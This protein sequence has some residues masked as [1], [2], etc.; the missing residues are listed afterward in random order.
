MLP[1]TILNANLLFFFGKDAFKFAFCLLLKT[2]P[3]CV[4]FLQSGNT[5]F[6]PPKNSI[7]T[8]LL[9]TLNPAQREAVEN[10]ETAS[11]IIA[12]AG[13]GKTRVLTSR[14]AY[15]LQKGVAPQS[16]LALTFTNKAAREMR[17]R[18]ALVAG[19]EAGRVVMG[20][21]HSIFLRIL[22]AEADKIGFD[23]NFTIYDTSD[24]VSLIKN[25]IKEMNLAD[26]VY[27]PKSVYAR[28]SNLKNELVTPMK[29]MEDAVSMSDDRKRQQPMFAE[30]YKRYAERCKANSAMDFD[31]ML[32]YMNLLL[33]TRADVLEKYQQQFR[34]ILVDEYQDTNYAQYRIVK[35]LGKAHG[36][37]CVVGD[38]SQSIYSFRGARIENIQG[39][40][41]DFPNA[42][43]YKLEQNYRSTQTIVNAANS[44]IAHNPQQR[45]LKKECFSTA[46]QGDKIRVI[47]G[48]T[49]I[50]E[51]ELIA[52]DIRSKVREGEGYD[53]F[54][55]LY[56]VNARSRVIEDAL[57]RRD[58]PY[59]IYRGHSFFDRKEVKDLVAYM[60]LIVNPKDDEAL[61]RIINF[62]A[63]G[64]GDVSVRKVED[65]A[66]AKGQSMW[67]VLDTMDY[68]RAKDKA[69]AKKVL[70]FTELIREL[71]KQRGEMDV[72]EFGLQVATRSGLIAA[73]K[74]EDG[75]DSDAAVE[76][77]YEVLNSI[78]Q[79]AEERRAEALAEGVE[80]PEALTLEDWLQNV[81]LMSDMDSRN[82][83]DDDS[84]K[85]TLMT[86][87]SSKGLE[88][89][90]VYIAGVEEEQFPGPKAEL[91][92]TMEE[93]RRLFYVAVT[94]AKK[95]AVLSYC[96]S[97]FAMGQQ[98]WCHPS[99]FIEEI[100]ER[101]ISGD[102]EGFRREVS[103]AVQSPTGGYGANRR[104]MQSGWG[105]RSTYQQ[106]PKP[107]PQPR[108]TVVDSR[109]QRVGVRRATEE[110]VE[111]AATALP[112]SSYRIGQ[113]VWHAK[114][115]E[116][117]VTGVEAM[118]TDVK[119]T[120]KF[121]DAAAGQK[122]LLSKFAKLKIVE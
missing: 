90:R 31:D 65:F 1:L 30:I 74:S 2:F 4:T 8:D 71:S 104:P 68:E 87:H 10:F 103:A 121:A 33:H 7:V 13:S 5:I 76:N 39:F 45:E 58:I 83:E 122:A 118:A 38:D 73:Y 91:E 88:F 6:V 17:E 113:K 85:V 92:G 86:I 93:E 29:Y 35:L 44:V 101:Y 41:R 46:E 59:V 70:V 27:K 96:V 28:I 98:M 120:V 9:S 107:A 50:E 81:A 69:L 109:F 105:G 112:A 37:V 78:Q 26:D 21:F 42:Q 97:R 18:I 89:G 100:D 72:Y 106:T 24:S 11:L 99:R 84:P 114:F 80:S 47:R 51:A 63:R 79:M 116:G 102:V 43:I 117:V 23:P 3:G 40:K 111:A 77:I 57:R 56:R 32:L 60:R 94:R 15:M 49:D 64:I 25:I 12:G 34:Y 115:G 19:P 67:E 75:K 53:N 14:I 48:Y 20:T 36:R 66:K 22:R 62:P 95:A 54:A 52:S 108:P 110:A 55:I 82:A 119:I 61:K 16:I